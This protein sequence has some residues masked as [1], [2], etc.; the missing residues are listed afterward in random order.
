MHQFFS[1]TIFIKTKEQ[2]KMRV[3]DLI[4]END[5]FFQI[6]ICNEIIR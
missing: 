3:I 2:E 4:A 1:I 6:Y 5:P